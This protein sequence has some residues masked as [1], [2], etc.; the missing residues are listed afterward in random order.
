MIGV[1]TKG[2]EWEVEVELEVYTIAK[3]R[4]P[5]PLIWSDIHCAFLVLLLLAA[6]PS[7]K[8]SWSKM[9]YALLRL[10]LSEA[11]TVQVLLIQTRYYPTSTSVVTNGG[12]SVEMLNA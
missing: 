12:R 4:F 6:N 9:Y 1:E 7:D 5:T 8:C 10:S 2:R 3:K 11:A